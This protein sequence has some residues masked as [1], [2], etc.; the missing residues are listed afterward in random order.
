MNE[1]YHFN[2]LT[3]EQIE[4][5]KKQFIEFHGSLDLCACTNCNLMKDNRCVYQFDVYNTIDDFCLMEK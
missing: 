5:A 2:R 1:D 4:E 3:D